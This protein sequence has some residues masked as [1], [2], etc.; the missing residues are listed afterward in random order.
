MQVGRYDVSLPRE[1]PDGL[2]DSA[3]TFL[4]WNFEFSLLQFRCKPFAHHV[5][6]ANCI[7]TPPSEEGKCVPLTRCT[8]TTDLQV[9]LRAPLYE[10]AAFH[11]RPSEFPLWSFSS[12][13]DADIAHSLSRRCG[14]TMQPPGSRSLGKV[15]KVLVKLWR[16]RPPLNIERR[17]EVPKIRGR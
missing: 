8:C 13:R 17:Q 1:V 11:G 12:P 9:V 7:V 3:R 2:T 14:L 4:P 6:M 16:Q 10:Y 15:T 5:T